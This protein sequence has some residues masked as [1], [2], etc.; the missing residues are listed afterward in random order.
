VKN[1]G[2]TSWL[3]ASQ[4]GDGRAVP[5]LENVSLWEIQFRMVGSAPRSGPGISRFMACSGDGAADLLLP[6][7]RPYQTRL[8]KRK[9]PYR[10]DGINGTSP[11]GGDDTD[12]AAPRVPH[13]DLIG[14]VGSSQPVRWAASLHSVTNRDLPGTSGPSSIPITAAARNWSSATGGF[15]AK[16]MG[17]GVLSYFGS[18]RT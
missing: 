9:I 13:M 12:T 16:Y 18:A 14:Y 5:D 4:D 1:V 15:V 10:P 6:E 3:P 8:G 17:D 2:R 7:A 11:T